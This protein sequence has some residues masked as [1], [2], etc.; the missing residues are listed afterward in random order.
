MPVRC[1]RC[2]INRTTHNTRGK[3]IWGTPQIYLTC[4]ECGYQWTPGTA[5]C[6][7]NAVIGFVVFIVI[8][9]LAIR[10]CSSES[11]KPNQQQQNQPTSQS[12]ILSENT[13]LKSPLLENKENNREDERKATV[14]QAKWHKWIS[15]DGNFSVEAK[16]ISADP[17]N[18]Y[19]EKKNG[20][21]IKVSREKISQED[22]DWIKR[23]PWK[24]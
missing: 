8:I 19:L 4:L 24:K 9:V 12:P 14:E 5:P 21:K 16:F 7:C 3:T 6:G 22:L 2:K 17:N 10:S 13:S 23:M 1:P 15:A 20:D 18:I 11:N